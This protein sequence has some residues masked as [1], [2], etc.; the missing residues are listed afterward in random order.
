MN[1]NHNS[2]DATVFF[3]LKVATK[4]E[5][6]FAINRSLNHGKPRSLTYVEPSI[7]Q[8]NRYNISIKSHPLVSP[9]ANTEYEN[10][11]KVTHGYH[12]MRLFWVLICIFIFISTCVYSSFWILEEKFNLSLEP[13]TKLKLTKSNYA[14]HDDTSLQ[15]EINNFEK[16]NVKD[17][18]VTKQNEKKQNL[19]HNKNSVDKQISSRAKGNRK[20]SFDIQ[21][22][23]TL[24]VDL[25]CNGKVRRKKVVNNKVTFNDVPSVDCKISFKRTGI[26]VLSADKNG[27]I[28][29]K[30][31][32]SAIIR[33]SLASG[34]GCE[35]QNP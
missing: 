30:S 14:I 34:P 19:L 23:N 9:K 24:A 5:P 16:Q 13:E 2:E 18:I 12:S 11:K 17:K 15:N 1:Q 32:F 33:V 21:G 25:T 4:M 26:S 35:P 6:N 20:I 31:S 22:Q 27:K 3:P 10:R 8:L 28:S 29:S 7:S